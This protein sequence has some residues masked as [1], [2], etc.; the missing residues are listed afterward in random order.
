MMS[1]WRAAFALLR[2]RELALAIRRC[3]FCGPSIIVRLRNDEIGV[4]CIRCGAS[5]VHLSIGWALLAMKIDL[6]SLDVCEL[7][8]RGPFVKFLLRKCRTVATSEYFP[9]AA[10]GELRDGVRCEDAQRLSYADASFDLV[11]HTEVFEHVPDDA[12]AFAE[13]RRVLRAGGAMVFTAPMLP[14][15]ATIERA[16]L[17]DGHIEHI[18]P[19]T[20]HRDP[21]R[22]GADILVFRQYGQNI[23]ERIIAAGFDNARLLPVPNAVPWNMGRSV[24][25]AFLA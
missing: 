19:P 11:T 2:P 22:Q 25:I 18:Q 13:L 1:R 5:A 3:P 9:D 6:E 17:I 15:L 21:S 24:V 16:R 12:K 10:P 14:G 8:A 4:R 20:Y 23:V 7:S